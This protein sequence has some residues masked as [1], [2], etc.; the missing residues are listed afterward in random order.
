M[1]TLAAPLTWPE[2]AQDVYDGLQTY[3][4]VGASACVVAIMSALQA[5]AEYS[6][7]PAPGSAYE[8]IADAGAL[9]CALKPST[10]AYAN[11]IQWILADL[12]TKADGQVIRSHIQGRVRS[13]ARYRKESLERIIDEARPILP[14]NGHVLI[15]DYSSTV[16]AVMDTAGRDGTPL[17]VFVTAG[18]PVGQG[19]KVAQAL[20]N[21]G[22]RI[23]YLPDAGVGRVMD[24]VDLVLSG[25]ETLFRNGDL[26]NTVGT[27]PIALVA[28]AADVPLYAATECMKIH[29]GAF[30]ATVED[31]TA[32]VL[33][34]WPP[35]DHAL[36]AGTD[37][38]REVLDL[39]PA[40][41]ITGY[42]TELGILRPS[43]VAGAFRQFSGN[44]AG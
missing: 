14:K 41:L 5:I 21:A 11:A 30:A 40:A 22:H 32:C 43:E 24:R 10:A 39:T 1:C 38:R 6:D 37:V 20:S 16:L 44:L 12:D 9:F 27:Y 17:T 33:H 2:E 19:A 15:H 26:A 4:I 36:P 31:L 29:P 35:H 25:V 8:Q 3:R 42:I 7:S 18:E 13:Y 23:V 34:P 28:R